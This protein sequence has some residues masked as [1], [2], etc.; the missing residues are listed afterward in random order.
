MTSRLTFNPVNHS[1]YL[2]DPD[3][4]KKTRL[5]SVTTLLGQLDKPALKKWAARTAADFAIDHWDNLATEPPSQRHAAIA[6]APWVSRD[7]AAAKGTAVHALAERL[8]LGEAVEVPETIATKVNH[9]ARWLE[10]TSLTNVLSEVRVWTDLDDDLR[11][12]GYAGTSDMIA[13]HP[14]YGRCILDWKT[15][16]GPWPEMAVQLAAYAAADHLVIGDQ[17]T[18]MPRVD[19]LGVVMVRESGCELHLIPPDSQQVAAERFELLR[20]LRL[21]PEPY[22]RQEA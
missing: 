9:V 5:P 1:Y 17:D 3:T 11:M 16:S 2:A 12:C 14:I 18:R 22:L 4:G 6:N 15:G 20:M 8:L 19:T 13:N 21:I 10:Q 7:T